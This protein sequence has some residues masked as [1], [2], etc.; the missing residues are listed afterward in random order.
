MPSTETSAPGESEPWR[1]LGEKVVGVGSSLKSLASEQSVSELGAALDLP[2]RMKS[3]PYAVLGVALG[4]G[5]VFGGGLSSWV[6]RRLLEGGLKVGLQIA[7]IPL[8]TAQIEALMSDPERDT[9]VP[10][11]NQGAEP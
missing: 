6:T 9:P 10:A 2:R 3:N 4:A 8:L 1:L 11:H 5:Y 7:I